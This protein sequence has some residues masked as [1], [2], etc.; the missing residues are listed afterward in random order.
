MKK[1][2]ALLSLCLGIAL[3]S[4]CST[5]GKVELPK[6]SSKGYTTYRLYRDGPS[7]PN[8]ANR[9]DEVNKIIQD[10]LARELQAHGLNRS[11]EDAELIVA[12]LVVTQTTAVTTAISNYYINSGSDILSEAHRRML[13]KD[14]PGSFEQGALIIDIIDKNTGDLIY[15][16]FAKREILT[17]LNVDERNA[18][19]KSAVNEALAAFF[20]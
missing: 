20:K 3:L 17:Y 14:L 4:G 5:T 2:L 19:V 6:G 11:P 7:D 18:R 8:F 10:E 12:Y 9:E 13:K 16:D 1:I 15:R